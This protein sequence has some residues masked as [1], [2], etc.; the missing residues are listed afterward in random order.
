M[1]INDGL[2]IK[3]LKDGDK[4]VF[5]YIF[6]SNYGMLCRFAGQILNDYCLAEEIADDVIVYLWEHREVLS[7]DISLRSYLMQSVKNRCI[8]VLRSS[9]YRQEVSF[10][11][12]SPEDNLD[13]LDTIFSDLT[14]PMG[15]LIRKELEERLMYYV[16]QLPKE[17]RII[18]EKS[19]FEQKR[20]EEIAEELHISVN[21]VKY[22][23]KNALAYLQKA[24]SGYLKILLLFFFIEN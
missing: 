17:C 18:F 2:L 3:K 21:T 14:H 1:K 16:G 19:R 12:I 13:F 23:I 22:H 6:E 8:D 24:L 15:V 11:T 9:R 20:Y 5:K 10:T 7:I 4:A